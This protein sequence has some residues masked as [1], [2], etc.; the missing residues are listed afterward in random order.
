MT[1]RPCGRSSCRP[2]PRRSG[3]SSS[4]PS[5]R[6]AATSA[7]TSASSS[8]P[9]RC[10]ACSTRRATP[11]VFDTG[12]QAYVHKLLTGRATTS[13][14]CKQ[15][16]GLSGYPSR[17][18]SE[19]DVV[20]N[21]PRLDVAVLGRRHRQGATRSR[22]ERDRHVVAVIGDGALT[23]GM[24]WEALNNIAAAKD[25]ALVIVVNDNGRSYAPTIGGLADHLATLRTSP[26]LR[27]VLELGQ[28]G[29]RRAPRSS[30]APLYA[31]LHAM[32]KGIKD[33]VAPQGHVRGPRPQVLRPGR[34]PRR[35]RGRAALRQARALR[36]PGDRARRSPRRAAATRPPSNDEADQFHAVGRFDPETGLP[37]AGR[38]AGS[39]PTCSP[40]SSSR[41]APS[42]PTSSR[43]PRR[44]C[45]P[46]GLDGVRRARFPERVFDVG[47]AEQHARR[48]RPP[49]WPSAGLHPVVAVYATFLNRAFDQLLHGLRAA[50]GRRH[51]RARPRRRHRQRRRRRTTACGTCRSCGDRAGPA[52]GRAARR[53]PGCARSCARPSTSPT[54]RPCCA[55]PR[56]TWPSRSPRCERCGSR[57][58]PRTARARDRSTCCSSASASMAVHGGGGRREAAGAGPHVRVVD[59]R[60]VLP[61]SDDLV[62]AARA[63]G[64]GGRRRGQPRRRRH[65]RGR[66]GRAARR[67]ASTPRCTCTASPSEFL[68][69]ASRGQVLEQVGLTAD[70]IATSLA[71][72]LSR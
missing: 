20:E 19:H 52:A 26:R 25:R 49:G 54:G 60:W 57:R 27:A 2:W 10:T 47:I 45:I 38:A 3:P 56:A 48:P 63:A 46:V 37:I 23:G 39:G 18:E 16:G 30:A 32:K 22:G 44:C 41:S 64:R 33:V 35:R 28:A 71:A 70:S 11:I 5:P 4:T 61:V 7:P 15:Q 66:D 24:A 69:H 59:P 34:R 6:P 12:H 67:R 29:A 1:S 65:R 14:G 51:V 17:A 53:R 68:D 58:R 13:S 50:P 9:S 31:A 72:A 55:S 36:R 40:T 8:S 62:E 21:S 42:A 43:S